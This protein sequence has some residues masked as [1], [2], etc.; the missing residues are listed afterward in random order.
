MRGV[1]R[2]TEVESADNEATMIV[3]V[4]G[5]ASMNRKERRNPHTERNKIRQRGQQPGTNFCLSFCV[6]DSTARLKSY[7]GARWTFRWR[8]GVWNIRVLK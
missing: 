2:G 1:M 8:S 5:V 3:S 6:T 4:L 7:W